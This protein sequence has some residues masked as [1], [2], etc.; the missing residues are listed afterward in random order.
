MHHFLT[1]GSVYQD[2]DDAQRAA[3]EAIDERL[4]QLAD[5]LP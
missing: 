3:M 2:G 1:N 5:A 4:M